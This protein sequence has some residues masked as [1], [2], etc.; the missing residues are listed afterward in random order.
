MQV[1]VLFTCSSYLNTPAIFLCSFP[2]YHGPFDGEYQGTTPLIAIRDIHLAADNDI[3][4]NEKA[5][6]QDP[7]HLRTQPSLGASLN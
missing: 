6:I 3:T 2:L 4:M 1:T 5:I 7:G